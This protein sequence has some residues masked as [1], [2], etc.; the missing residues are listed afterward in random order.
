MLTTLATIGSIQSGQLVLE[1]LAKETVDV[2]NA[3]F[4]V[5]LSVIHMNRE[6]EMKDVTNY[7]NSKIRSEATDSEEAKDLVVTSKALQRLFDGSS[8]QNID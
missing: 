8:I 5:P 4:F 7:I 1:N 6:S 3:N 2:I